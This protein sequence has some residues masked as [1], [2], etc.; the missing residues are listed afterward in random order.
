MP[1]MDP[2]LVDAL[3][4]SFYDR[5]VVE[6]ARGLLG[7]LLVRQ[8]PGGLTAGRIVESE[9]YLACGD[10]ACHSARGQTRKNL[11][12]FGQ[13]GRA[14]VYSIHARWCFNVVAEPKR[15]ASAVLVRAVEPLTG[16]SLMQ[17]RRRVDKLTDLA[18][19]PARL[20]EA[21]QIDRRLDG[22]N[23]SRGR[24][25]WI[26]ADHQPEISAVDIGCSPRIG[27]TSAQDLHLRFYLRDNPY[28]SGPK[29][30][31]I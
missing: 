17:R 20:C 27:V 7:K 26:A 4:Q 24:R 11:S 15:V 18:R 8:S 23:L 9:A 29:R 12:M 1:L 30:W 16:V 6:V 2:S 14:Y 31:R 25:L 22:W 10:P 5:D 13:P 21:F 19:G 28:V 3:P